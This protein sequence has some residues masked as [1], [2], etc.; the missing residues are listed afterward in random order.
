MI[1]CGNS[2]ARAIDSRE[3]EL[4][5]LID[6]LHWN[7][8][9]SQH[10][11]LYSN[12]GALECDKFRTSAL[13][14]VEHMPASILMLGIVAYTLPTTHLFSLENGKPKIADDLDVWHWF[15]NTWGRSPN[16]QSSQ[17][18]EINHYSWTISPM[19]HT[20]TYLLPWR[21]VLINGCKTRRC[22]LPSAC[23]H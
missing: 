3:F 9:V 10:T 22:R 5:E 23:L 20:T 18:Q 7:F 12:Q 21:C 19:L 16:Q 13:L 4:S 6:L 8:K 14:S 2:L 17:H 1:K 11:D 15:F